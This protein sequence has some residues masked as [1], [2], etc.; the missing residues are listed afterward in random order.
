[1]RY[2]DT[3]TMLICFGLCGFSTDAYTK[4]NNKHSAANNTWV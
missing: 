3:I 2:F 1:M 4:K